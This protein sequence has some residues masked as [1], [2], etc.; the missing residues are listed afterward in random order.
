V[1][2]VDLGEIV[3]RGVRERVKLKDGGKGGELRNIEGGKGVNKWVEGRG[4]K[5]GEE[6]RK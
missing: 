1:E 3:L 4:R 5:V 2:S 6:G